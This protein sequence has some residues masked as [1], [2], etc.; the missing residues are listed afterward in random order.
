MRITEG[1]LHNTAASKHCTWLTG[2]HSAYRVPSP[3]HTHTKAVHI[4]VTPQAH[5][6]FLRM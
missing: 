4:G 5:A 6:R 3:T 1:R 2:P